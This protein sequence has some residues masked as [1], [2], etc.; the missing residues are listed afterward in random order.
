MNRIA[1]FLVIAF[2]TTSLSCLSCTSSS[3]DLT[4]G[5]AFPTTAMVNVPLKFSA[6]IINIGDAGTVVRFAYFFQVA[7]GPRG[8]GPI[9]DLANFTMP[10]LDGGI[11][12]DAISP[13]YTFRHSGTHSVRVCADKTDRNGGAV[14]GEKNKENNCGP[15]IAV[16][17]TLPIE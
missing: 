4:A 1:M 15:W 12:A 13:S 2:A 14:V 10:P 6:R 5:P 16:E 7:N 8:E 3:P 11:G 9:E 17:V